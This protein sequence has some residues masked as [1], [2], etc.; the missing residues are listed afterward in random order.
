M[1]HRPWLVVIDAQRAFADPSSPW[2]AP[3]FPEILGPIRDLVA[4]HGDRVVQTRWVPPHVKHGSWVDYFKEFPFADRE[5]HDHMFDLVDEIADLRL[6]HTVS[7]S[8]FGKWDEHLSQVVRPDA[9]LV[10]AGVTT[11]CC[12]LS[13]ALAAADAGCRVEVVAAACAGSS[14]EAQQHALAL[15]RGYAP[16]ITVR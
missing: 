11:D 16:Q 7:E 6:P 12:V 3:R 13:T 5:Q 1:S 10:L 4:A 2:C 8:T 9:H 14:D 15:L